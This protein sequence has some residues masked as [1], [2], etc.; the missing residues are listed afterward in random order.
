MSSTM[1]AYSPSVM[2]WRSRV[3]RSKFM[4]GCCCGVQRAST[5][6]RVDDGLEQHEPVGAADC[7]FARTFG[8]RHQPDDVSR[9]VADASNVLERSIRIRGI[10]GLTHVVDVTEHNASDGPQL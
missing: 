10:G 4:S 8:M 5:R 3:A 9:L 7:R 2:P 1:R 6:K